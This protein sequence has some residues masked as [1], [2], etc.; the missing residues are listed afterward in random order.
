MKAILFQGDSIT[1][2]NR[3]YKEKRNIF[4]RLYCLL[5]KR[6]PLGSGYA[7]LVAQ[8][9][10]QDYIYENRGISGNRIPDVYARRTADIFDIKPDYM[11]IL[12]G[13]NDIW[14]GLDFKKGTS[15]DEFRQ[16]YT[17][18]IEEIREKLPETKIM[19]LEPFVLEGTATK[20]SA[21]CPDKYTVFRNGVIELAKITEGIAQKY[22]LTFIRLQEKLDKAA[23]HTDAG[24][25]LSDGVHPTEEGHRII[26]EEW[27][28]AFNEIK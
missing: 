23:E 7:A 21:D 12:I 20:S 24:L 18:L 15:P 11:S 28:K 10:G 22:N 17:A 19:L 13:V 8:Q 2:C 6:T 14:H 25:I 5:K 4:I 1:D 27:I 3:L 26:A 16:T 9:L